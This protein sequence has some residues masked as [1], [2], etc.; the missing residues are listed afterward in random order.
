MHKS[1]ETPIE[2]TKAHT[3]FGPRWYVHT[4]NWN[5][6]P[7][8]HAFLLT[9]LSNL[10]AQQVTKYVRNEDQKRALVSQLLQVRSRV[11]LS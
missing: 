5:P 7:E 1:F 11:T 8:Q 4:V 9:L 10:E 3:A 6:T 2:L